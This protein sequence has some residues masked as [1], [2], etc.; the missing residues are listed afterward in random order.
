MFED[1]KLIGDS[2][3]L[4]CPTVVNNTEDLNV[5]I[6]KPSGSQTCEELIE[7]DKENTGGEE[8]ELAAAR[9]AG[10]ERRSDVIAGLRSGIRRVKTG[11]GMLDCWGGYDGC[12]YRFFADDMESDQYFRQKVRRFYC[13]DA[14][15]HRSG[16][17]V[18]PKSNLR[19][20]H[21]LVS[22]SR[23]N[24]LTR[25]ENNKENS[26][27]KCVLFS[28]PETRQDFPPPPQRERGVQGRH[29]L[30]HHPGRCPGWHH[31]PPPTHR[32]R[33]PRRSHRRG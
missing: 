18:F 21:A 1:I 12:S 25:E 5:L 16:R 3:D 8:D 2:I 13:I 10:S 6:Y 29:Q 14:F 23:N 28:L 20:C 32:P 24:L 15:A 33:P 17:L 22:K 31:G 19:F 4:A 30:P 11:S 7:E 9:R 26:A 27:A